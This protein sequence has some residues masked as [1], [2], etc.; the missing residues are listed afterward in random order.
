MSQSLLATRC[1]DDT[2]SNYTPGSQF[3]NNLKGLLVSLY[4]HGSGSNFAYQTTQGSYP[5]K[6][7]GLFICRGDLSTDTCQDC[8]DV[9]NGKIQSDCQYKKEGTI[10]YD[11]CVIRYSYTSFFGTFA[12]EPEN[13]IC[14]FNNDVLKDS[15]DSTQIQ[16]MFG[17]LIDQ[18]TNSTSTGLYAKGDVKITSARKVY[19]MVQCTQ[20]LSLSQCSDCLSSALTKFANTT[21]CPSGKIGKRILTPSCNTRY[22]MYPFLRNRSIKPPDLGNRT[23]N[24]TKGKFFNTCM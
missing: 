13:C 16:R 23:H 9:A 1:G 2:N 10:W 24:D 7:Y 4:D 3:Q 17:N 12:L 11:E 15:K 5:D 19:G 18:A 20:D 6:V 21:D 14:Y 8:I 22:E